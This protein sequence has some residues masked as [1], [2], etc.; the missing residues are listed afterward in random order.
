MFPVINSPMLSN[1]GES[2]PPKSALLLNIESVVVCFCKGTHYI[3]IYK[4]LGRE[5]T[6][7]LGFFN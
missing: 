7:K 6:V 3:W 4:H 5:F 1:T 2:S